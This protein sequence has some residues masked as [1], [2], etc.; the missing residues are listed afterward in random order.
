MVVVLEMPKSASIDVYLKSGG[1]AM[2]LE[3]S[4]QKLT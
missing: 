3:K 1:V 2:R 4:H